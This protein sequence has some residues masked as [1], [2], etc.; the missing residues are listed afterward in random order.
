MDCS[1]DQE[2]KSSD[3]EMPPLDDGPLTDPAFADFAFDDDDA[4]PPLDGD[5]SGDELPPP[6]L[7]GGGGRRSGG[8]SKEES[9]A[10]AETK[11]CAPPST[12]GFQCVVDQPSAADFDPTPFEVLTAHASV[13]PACTGLRF[14]VRWRVLYT[15]V[16]IFRCARLFFH[17]AG[18]YCIA[19]LS[20]C[21]L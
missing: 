16:Y 2:S 1:G 5:H 15:Y 17:A 8:E 3:D 19:L 20:F 10:L 6:W 9:W 21:L 13:G 7:G 14:L 4:P 12:F 18:G 11:E